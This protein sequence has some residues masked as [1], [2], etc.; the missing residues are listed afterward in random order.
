VEDHPNALGIPI[1]AVLGGATP[2]V[3]FVNTNNQIE[4][5]LVQLGLETPDK[6]EVVSGLQEGDLVVVGN[7]SDT[8]N[9]QKVEPKLS[10]LTMRDEN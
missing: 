5:R 9:G 4:Q 1:E 6:Y 3:L 8:Q 7:H 10:A 2:P